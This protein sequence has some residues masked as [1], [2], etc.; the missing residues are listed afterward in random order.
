MGISITKN[1]LPR[2]KQ[3]VNNFAN[4]AD[5]LAETLVQEAMEIA[6]IHYGNSGALYLLYYEKE[7]DGVYKLIA[8]GEQIAYLEF[9]T[10][11]LGEGKYPDP[12]KL[13]PESMILRFKSHGHTQETAGWVYNYYK[14]KEENRNNPN[15][16]D[17]QGAEPGAQMFKTAKEL[18]EELIEIAKEYAKWRRKV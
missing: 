8:E 13:P 3:R 5:E 11:I 7:R 4:M 15:V 16:K 9:G 12:N 6:D 1:K 14:K 10:G 2:F 17:W 18:G